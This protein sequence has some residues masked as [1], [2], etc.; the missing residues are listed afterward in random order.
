MASTSST[1]TE[2]LSEYELLRKRNIERNNAVMKALGLGIIDFEA[3][4][5]HKQ[6]KLAG[7]KKK[8]PSSPKR[9]R[10]PTRVSLR[11]AGQAAEGSI[12]IGGD[13]DAGDTDVNPQEKKAREQRDLYGSEADHALA[14]AQHLRWAGQQGKATIVGT[15]SYK[16]TL[17]R[18]RTMAENALFNR[19][20]AI[21]RAKGKHAVTKM[22]LFARVLCLEGLDEVAEEA[23]F[24][25][26]RLIDIL[27]DPGEIAEEVESDDVSAVSRAN[28]LVSVDSETQ[29]GDLQV[30]P[31]S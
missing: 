26:A 31:L 24:S 4:A 9:K 11:V 29:P 3:H 20:K 22:R 2:E 5:A 10:D 28:S 8:Q 1:S 7:E 27:G 13:N 30:A 21:E 23:T 18:V 12:T 14:E 15:A 16:H 25:L 17:M 19:V 6:T